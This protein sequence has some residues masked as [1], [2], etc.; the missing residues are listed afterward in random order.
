MELHKELIDVVRSRR[1]SKLIDPAEIQ[2]KWETL[3][4]KLV[5]LKTRNTEKKESNVEIAK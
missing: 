2:A 1:K 5:V 3:Q 4:D